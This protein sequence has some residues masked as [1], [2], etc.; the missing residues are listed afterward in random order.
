[1]LTYHKKYWGQRAK[2]KHIKFID[3]NSN[4][5]HR[6]AS[7]KRNRKIIREISTTEGTLIVGVE[8]IRKEIRGDFEKRFKKSDINTNK[9]HMYLHNITNEVT[10]EDNELLTQMATNEEIKNALFGIGCNK[11][12][13]PDGM[14][15]I[16]YQ[17]YWH[18]VGPL[19]T[20]AVKSFFH[21][22][23]ILKQINHTFI[24]LI[25]KCDNPSNTNHYRPISLCS[26]I[27]KI[28]SKI[29]TNRLKPLL[30]KLIHPL[31]GA[32]V[33]DRAIQDNILIAHEIFHSFKSRKGLEDW[34]ALKL[35]M[36]KAYDQIEWEIWI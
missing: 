23:K 6:I 20:K 27:Y 31:Q 28:I 33:A 16:F 21:S 29:I 36:E 26:T 22:G 32:F 24:T 17:K 9:L 7:A 2:I 34:M 35:D 19:I 3:T 13:G 1:M 4:Y 14:S 5:F 25:P 15:A 8:N 10:I 12:P 30:Q 11:S 18:I